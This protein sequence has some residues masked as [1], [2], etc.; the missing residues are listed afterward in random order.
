LFKDA[1]SYE[2]I[3]SFSPG[4]QSN[5]LLEYL[6]HKETDTPLLIDQPEDN[7]D[8]STIYTQIRK[9]FFDM[10]K[11]RQL[12]VVT[13]D[14][15]IVI[16]SD[17]ENLIIASQAIRGDFKYIYGA[18]EWD[19]NIDYA[20]QILDGGKDAVKRRMMKYGE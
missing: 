20:S 2:D 18:L 13:H 7:V 14:A 1:L 3:K 10:K 4:M 12:I 9:W 5:I 17:S 11:R 15:N 16:N 6:V 8:N 19:K